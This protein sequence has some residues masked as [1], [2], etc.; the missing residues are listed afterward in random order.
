MGLTAIVTHAA[1]HGKLD[2]GEARGRF[3]HALAGAHQL[4][5]F[6]RSTLLLHNLWLIAED[7]KAMR[8]MTPPELT[9]SGGAVPSLTARGAGLAAVLERGVRKVEVGTMEGLAVLTASVLVPLSEVKPREQGMS[10]RRSYWLVRPDGR[11]RLEPGTPIA[12]GQHVFVELTLDAHDGRTSASTGM[13]LDQEAAFLR[14]ELGCVDAINLDGGGS[15][16][17]WVASQPT[18]GVTNYPSDN[19]RPDHFGER[20]LSNALLVFAEP[21]PRAPVFTSLPELEQVT[22]GQ[23]YAYAASAASGG[24]SVS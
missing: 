19:A 5:T 1:S 3:V 24:L 23:P 20:A 22:D 16:T 14:D 17:F 18:G 13:T 11:E 15:T 6:D 21:S 9:V 10:L 12:Q 8:D 2:R 4:S 7:T